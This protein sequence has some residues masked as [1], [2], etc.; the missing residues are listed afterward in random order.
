MAGN[1]KKPKFQPT[2]YNWEALEVEYI[3]GDIASVKEF[4][5]LRNI[6]QSTFSRKALGWGFKREAIRAQ[7]NKIIGKSLSREYADQMKAH[8]NWGAGLIKMG[9]DS[10]VPDEKMGT[11]GMK[12]TSAGE[13]AK[14]I[15]LGT[16]I[17]K[18]AIIT[19]ASMEEL[20]RDKNMGPGPGGV[21]GTKDNMVHVIIDLPSNQK[22]LPGK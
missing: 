4:F 8:L 19:T 12:P 14:L 17:Q 22:E 5:R 6:P 10:L 20:L 13:A 2:K 9:I 16:V 15:H 11:K 3:S 21:E 1:G 7:G 18:N